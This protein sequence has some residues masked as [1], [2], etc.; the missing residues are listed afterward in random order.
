VILTGHGH[1]YARFA[2]RNSQGRSASAF[3]VLTLTLHPTSYDWRFF[4]EAGRTFIDS[5]SHPCH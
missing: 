2:P 5:G 3:E 1:L 4:P